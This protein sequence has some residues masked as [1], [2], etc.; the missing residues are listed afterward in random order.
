MLGLVWYG[1]CLLGAFIW[2]V[3]SP[4]L[5]SRLS[6][7]EVAAGALAVGTIAPAYITY[8]VSCLLSSL[9]CVAAT[10]R[11]GMAPPHRR[12]ALPAPAGTNRSSFPTSS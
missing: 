8:L 4:A 11:R 7:G 12:C 9:E 2:L 1:A 10:L 5:S 3:G 6:F